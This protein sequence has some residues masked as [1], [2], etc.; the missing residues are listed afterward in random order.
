MQRLVHALVAASLA[1][2]MIGVTAGAASADRWWGG[3]RHGDVRQ[4]HFVPAPPPCGIVEEGTAPQDAATDIVGLSVRHEAAAVE[5]RA[6]L[7]DLPPVWG[8]RYLSFDLQTDRRDY[9]ITIQRLRKRGPLETILL[10]AARPPESVDECGTYYTV[11]L[12]VS[13]PE[14]LMTRSTDRDV[15]S[16]E[17]PHSCVGG[18][19]W[20]RAGVRNFRTVQDRYRSDVWGTGSDDP[21]AYTGPFGPR[22][23]HD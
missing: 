18:P 7:R 13:C 10:V 6:H 23:R 1:S 9:E 20:V 21:V 12:H 2:T 17:L 4:I 11:Q 3:D 22:V 8:D 14:L 16:V 15:V 19:R 5:V